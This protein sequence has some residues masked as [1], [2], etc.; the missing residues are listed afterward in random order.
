MA[1]ESAEPIAKKYQKE[2]EEA[3]KRYNK[4]MGYV[5][6]PP[7]VPVGQTPKEVIWTRNKAQL[8]HY[9]PLAE[10]RHAEPLLM[11][12]SLM[13][14]SFIVDLRPGSSL[15]EFLLRQGYEVYLLDWG[16]PGPEDANLKLDDYVLDY[17]PRAL[18]HTLRHSGAEQV[19]L[20]GYCLGA[21][22]SFC[23]SATHTD[24]PIKNLVT[25][26]IP[27]DFTEQQLFNEWLNPKQFNLNQ[28]LEGYG[29][30]PGEFMDLGMRLKDPVAGFITS[31]TG[32]FDKVLDDRAVESW[33][34]MQKW[35]NDPIPF[36]GAAFKQCAE[37]MWLGNKLIKSELVLRGQRVDL[38]KITMSYL[39][40]L[41]ER[42]TIV[43]ASQSD[44]ALEVV[45]SQDKEQVIMPGGHIGLA[46]G[47]MASKG[48]WPALD[49]WLSARSTSLTVSN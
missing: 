11:I 5:N 15:I 40:I 21:V 12:Y 17:M 7:D 34:S 19:N 29:N 27:L 2:L 32:F 18:K 13:N 43:L 44:K 30:I 14:K 38:S 37:E 23:F 33:I 28:V 16:I 10:R 1:T 49:R 20:I 24:A 42:D 47:R 46:V 31:Y 6:S 25:L 48:L 41:A 39:N 9:L 8:Y 4:T 45:G 26:A 22:L 36:A 35:M 3:V